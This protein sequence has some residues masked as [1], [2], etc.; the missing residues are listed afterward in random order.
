MYEESGYDEY[1]WLYHG[2]EQTKIP[3]LVRGYA[4]DGSKSVICICG[5]EL[6]EKTGEQDAASQISMEQLLLDERYVEYGLVIEK[7]KLCLA[8]G[9]NRRL[10]AKQEYELALRAAQK[11]TIHVVY[12][13]REQIEEEA[14]GSVGASLDTGHVSVGK[15]GQE[16]DMEEGFRTDAY[17]AGR[18]YPFLKELGLAEFVLEALIVECGLQKRP[19]QAQKFLEDM[20]AHSASYQ[21]IYRAT[22]PILIYLGPSYCYNILNVFAKELGHAL[23]RSGCAVEY[24]DTE[25]EDVEGV[26]RLLG[27]Q[28]RASVG[29]Q[30]WLMSVKHGGG[31]QMLQDLIGGPKYNFIVDHPIWLDRQL[32]ETPKRFYVLTHD[33]NYIRF[34]REY[35][36]GVSGV[37]LLPPGGR[38]ICAVEPE[39]TREYDLVFLGTYR[40]YRDRI[41]ELRTY[42]NEKKS[43]AIR[44]LGM[45]KKK[46]ELTPEQA[47]DEA[48][49]ECGIRYD[50]VRFRETLFSLGLVIQLVMYYYREKVIRSILDAG[51]SIHVYGDA[52]ADSPFAD[53]SG[54]IRHPEIPAGM[55]MELLAAAKISLNIMA[56]HKDGFTER[57]ADSMLA[58]AVVVSDYSTQLA[59]YYGDE[60]VL[61][62]LK[63]LD[64]LPGLLKEMLEDEKRRDAI[65]EKARE[66]ATRLATWE[67]RAKELLKLV[68]MEEN[69]KE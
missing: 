13:N 53:H 37:Y 45:M 14:E 32:K 4:G 46:P 15:E 35:Y 30:T 42:P 52:W 40:N 11:E 10:L 18:Y 31:K 19:D 21:R 66:K 17:V 65:A 47:L 7:R 24:Y 20:I 59:E 56:W 57:V 27:R 49:K 64:R 63:R 2:I 16:A 41:N 50:A 39:G 62:D 51:L 67:K 54:L 6:K 55:S 68:E 28:Y 23:E 12:I 69:P 36:T 34:V 44:F 9:I 29:F 25:R 1:V 8:G 48:M 38:E 3:K 58:G 60:T 61:F 43:L 22:Q 33:R 26:G 5:P